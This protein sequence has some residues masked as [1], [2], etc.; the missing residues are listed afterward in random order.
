MIVTIILAKA[1]SFDFF[2]PPAKS[3]GIFSLMS[4][5]EKSKV[6]KD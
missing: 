4:S 2:I 3:G 5:V 1:D 6:E